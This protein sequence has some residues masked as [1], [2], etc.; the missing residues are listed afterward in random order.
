M[1]TVVSTTRVEQAR[2]PGNLDV[3][4]TSAQADKNGENYLLSALPEI[5]GNVDEQWANSF[6]CLLSA[7]IPA[8]GPSTQEPRDPQ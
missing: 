8:A 4:S 7:R 1:H 6:L 2:I 3:T 5:C